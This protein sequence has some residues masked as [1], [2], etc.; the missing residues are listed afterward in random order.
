[1]FIKILFSAQFYPKSGPT[2]GGTLVTIHGKNLGSNIEEV[3]VNIDKVKCN[4]TE[5]QAP[6]RYA[7]LYWSLFCLAWLVKGMLGWGKRTSKDGLESFSRLIHW[8]TRILWQTII[9]W[10]HLESRARLESWGRLKS[11]SH[12]HCCWDCPSSG[13]D[14]HLE[15]WG[16]GRDFPHDSV[17]KCHLCRTCVAKFSIPLQAQTPVGCTWP[18][19]E[20]HICR[21]VY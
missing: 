8:Q 14:L 15:E 10:I 5:L 3:Q 4:I 1:M 20:F 12:L 11:L 17:P 7:H 21:V 2:E 9:I 6:N 13:K 16:W 18:V 19:L